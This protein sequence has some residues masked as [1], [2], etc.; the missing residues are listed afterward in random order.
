MVQLRS[1]DDVLEWCSRFAKIIGE[2]L[3]VDVRLAR[4]AQDAARAGQ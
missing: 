3:E 2:D 1:H 4:E